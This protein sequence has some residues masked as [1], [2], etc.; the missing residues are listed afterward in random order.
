MAA[1]IAMVVVP[2]PPF[3]PYQGDHPT[4]RRSREEDVSRGEARQQALDPGEQLGWMEGF[5]EVVVRAGSQSADLLLHLSLGGEHDDRDMRGAAFFTPDL[6]R[7][8]VAVQLGQHDIE[9]DQ[10]GR[11]RAPQW[12]PSAPSAAVTTS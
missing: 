9:Q 8:L 11:F 3:A 2:T 10:I 6:G 12:N 7:H 5:D 4:H 1:L